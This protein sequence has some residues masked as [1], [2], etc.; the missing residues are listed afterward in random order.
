MQPFIPNLQSDRK[1]RPHRGSRSRGS[2]R[3]VP[4]SF[5]NRFASPESTEDA[6]AFPEHDR[7]A[8]R[9]KTKG[10]P[11][12]HIHTAPSCENHAKR[13]RAQTGVVAFS[14]EGNTANTVLRALGALSSLN[15]HVSFASLQ[16]PEPV[17]AQQYLAPLLCSELGPPC[18][19][20]S[21][22][23]LPSSQTH[24]MTLTPG[25]TVNICECRKCSVDS[26]QLFCY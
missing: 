14:L 26:R 12:A 17:S 24:P 18:S 3:N 1:I 13:S 8:I 23:F 9:A 2:R 4:S 5:V 25:H 15:V 20:R 21:G 7:I 22:D 6:C 10:D 16:L 11:G 19:L